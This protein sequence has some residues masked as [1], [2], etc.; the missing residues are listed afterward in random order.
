MPG[1]EEDKSLSKLISIVYKNGSYWVYHMR[2]LYKPTGQLD[3]E[4]N[5]AEQAWQVVRLHNL[6]TKKLTTRYQH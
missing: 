5:H 3:K 6:K 4:F 2:T 1:I